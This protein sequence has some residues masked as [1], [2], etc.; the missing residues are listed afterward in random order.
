MK[1]FDLAFRLGVVFGVFGFIWGIIRLVISF[2]RFNGG[3]KTFVE[4]YSLKLIQYFF[5]TDVTFMFC[6]QDTTE[7]KILYN[8]LIVAISFLLMY[9]I[10]KLQRRQKSMIV[11]KGFGTSFNGL[12]PKFDLKAE[13]GVIIFSI[14]I[15]LFF[16]FKPEFAFNPIGK[17]FYNNIIGIEEA[18]FFGWIFKIVGFFVL[19]GIINKLVN[20]VFFLLSGKPLVTSSLNTNEELKK[21]SNDF[22]DFE[23][24]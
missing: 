2:F 20:G 12:K 1:F 23:E 21:D 16:S 5:L 17:W 24:V 8:E 3:E 19:L 10:G 13:I 14:T 11:M 9:F 18:P 22:D 7:I 15:F 4:E 6:V